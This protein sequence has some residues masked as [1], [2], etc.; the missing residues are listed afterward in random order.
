MKVILKQK[1][2]NEKE[3]KDGKRERNII[4]FCVLE[5]IFI[6]PENGARKKREKEDSETKEWREIRINRNIDRMTTDK[7]GCRQAASAKGM[8]NGRKHNARGE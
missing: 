6:S 5:I 7:A 1:E 8:T 4:Q 2:R 3:K